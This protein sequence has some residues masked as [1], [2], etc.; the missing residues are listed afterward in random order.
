MLLSELVRCA[1]RISE[2]VNSEWQEV[3]SNYKEQPIHWYV[4]LN[5]DGTRGSIIPTSG[6]SLDSGGQ[7]SVTRRGIRYPAPYLKRSGADIKPQLLVD[8]A[9]IV[10]GLPADSP[11]RAAKRHHEFKS[12]VR[13]CAEWTS[14]PEVMAVSNFLENLDLETLEVPDDMRPEHIVAFQVGEANPTEHLEVQHCWQIMVQH[15]SVRKIGELDHKRVLVWL[16]DGEQEVEGDSQCIVCGLRTTSTR[17]HPIPIQLPI[18]DKQLA[19]VTANKDAFWSYGLEQSHIAPT[20]KKCAET[21]A[22]A[23]NYL[24][25]QEGNHLR[26]GDLFYIFWTR[27][28]VKFSIAKLLSQPDPQHVKAFLDSMWSA[29]QST[30]DLQ[31]NQFFAVALSASG[32]RLVVRDWIDTTVGDVQRNL[33]RWFGLQRL[34]RPDGSESRPYGL[35]ALVGATQR[36]KA[37]DPAPPTIA[38]VLLRAAL[39]GGPLPA[40]LL[41]Q[42]LRRIRAEQGVTP[43]RATLI[44]MVLMSQRPSGQ[45]EED[46][47]TELNPGET[48]PAYL[49]GRLLAVLD[50]IQRAALGPRNATIIDRFYGTA[51]T[52]PASVFGRLL[53]GSQPHLGRL[54]RTRPSAYIALER[55]MEE[56]MSGL[57]AFPR[58]L[59]MDQQGLFALGYYHQRAA[60]AKARLERQLQ[61][62]ETTD[63]TNVTPEENAPLIDTDA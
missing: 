29:R 41:A 28:P 48:N 39:T 16:N 4:L 44:K 58:T 51:S 14:L 62:P 18:S 17:I 22:K 25:R 46:M 38:R 6:G 61:A 8:K 35:P 13:A 42:T 63:T 56:V 53:R 26:I 3:P 27:E 21:Y 52:A 19:M 40:W 57:P 2:S 10:L 7:S 1:N 55:R 23:I 5:H 49:C 37:R 12:L 11:E 36:E 43:V 9:E 47:L 24:A 50:A 59:T 34:V 30:H 33:A 31:A 32:A 45:D 15:L 60:D 54:R 20:C